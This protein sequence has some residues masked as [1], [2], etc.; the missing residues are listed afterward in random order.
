MKMPKYIYVCRNSWEI[1][2]DEEIAKDVENCSAYI[3]GKCSVD[4]KKCKLIKYKKQK[5]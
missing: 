4:D 5:L 3:K 1:I 2:L